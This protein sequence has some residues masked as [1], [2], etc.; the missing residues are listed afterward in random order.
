MLVVIRDMP[1]RFTLVFKLSSTKLLSSGWLNCSSSSV[2]MAQ[3]VSA[4]YLNL[5]SLACNRIC[6]ISFACSMSIFSFNLH[7][8]LVCWFSQKSFTYPVNWCMIFPVSNKLPITGPDF[9]NVW[10]LHVW[11][12]FLIDMADCLIFRGMFT[13]LSVSF[14]IY[15]CVIRINS[16]LQFRFY[17]LVRTWSLPNAFCDCRIREVT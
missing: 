1:A 6:S 8:R 13:F 17:F 3:E 9:D 15:V 5:A 11:F 12:N 2:P 7:S 10:S 4:S 14:I 16:L